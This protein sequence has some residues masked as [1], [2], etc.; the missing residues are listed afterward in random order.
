MTSPLDSLDP[1]AGL[2]LPSRPGPVVPTRY[3]S[4]RVLAWDTSTGEH[5][6]SV[7]GVE[8]SNLPMYPGEYV[9]LV[10]EGD[11]VSLLTTTDLRGLATLVITGLPLRPGDPRLVRVPRGE[12]VQR[13]ENATGAG[14]ENTATFVCMTIPFGRFLPFSV[15]RIRTLLHMYGNTDAA[16]NIGNRSRVQ[17]AFAGGTVLLACYIENSDNIGATGDPRLIDWYVRNNTAGVITTEVRIQASA[18]DSISVGMYGAADMVNYLE[19]EYVDA[20]VGNY[21]AAPQVV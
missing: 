7:D 10:R 3:R 2:F 17:L 19:I 12:R 20:P 18:A 13:V 8:L 9:E 21:P 5:T 14:P 4:G 11:V 15:Y 6:L 1:T 16:T